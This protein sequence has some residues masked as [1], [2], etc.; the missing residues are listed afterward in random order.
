MA[1]KSAVKKSDLIVDQGR[2]VQPILV[3]RLQPRLRS[4]EDLPERDVASVQQVQ[5]G[6][7][8]GPR[9]RTADAPGIR[10]AADSFFEEEPVQDQLAA[11]GEHVGQ[12]HVALRPGEEVLALDTRHRH[13][14]AS[15]REPVE[16]RSN[17]FHLLPSSRPARDPT[18]RL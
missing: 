16:L 14:C 6:H 18:R 1:P 13:A 8:L 7:A 10:P 3:V 12:R 9:R 4:G 11:A 17:G 15:S 5:V 2:S